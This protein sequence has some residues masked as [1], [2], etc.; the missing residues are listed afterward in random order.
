M[1]NL[2]IATDMNYNDEYRALE[3][4]FKL[5][6]NAYLDEL[7]TSPVRSLADVIRFNKKFSHLV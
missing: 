7:V 5:A 1:D 4:E 3:A 6:L 2:E